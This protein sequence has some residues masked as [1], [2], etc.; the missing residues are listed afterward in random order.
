M[1]AP[2][3]WFEADSGGPVSHAIAAYS[4]L[5]HCPQKESDSTV[6]KALTCTGWQA[7]V[8]TGVSGKAIMLL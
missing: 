5:A 2:G 8:G 4:A 1:G 7:L 3:V 6:R